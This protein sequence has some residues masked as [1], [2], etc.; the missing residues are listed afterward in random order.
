LKSKSKILFGQLAGIR[1]KMEPHGFVGAFDYVII[2]GGL[3]GGYAASSIRKI[4][5]TGKI[6]LVANE[7]HIPY[8]RVP[9]SKGYLLNNIPKDRLFFK[10]DE[11]YKKDGV[12]FILGHEVKELHVNSKMLKLDD[13]RELAFRKLLLATGGSPK[14]ILIPGSDLQGVY[15]LRTLE[16]CDLLKDVMGHSRRAVVIGGGFIGCELASAFA[17]KG[18]DTTIIEIGPCLL[19][20]AIDEET[21]LWI[22]N[23]YSDRGVSVLVNAT[24][25]KF[26]EENGRVSGIQLNDGRVISA[27][28]VVVGVGIALHTKLAERAG[29]KV[30]QG[31]VVNEFL[32]TSVEGIYAAGDVARFYSPIFKRYLRLEHYDIAVKHGIRA[33]ANMAGEKKPFNDLPYFFSYQFDLKI[34]AYGDLSQKTSMVKRGELNETEGFFQFYLNKGMLDAVLSINKKWEEVKKAKDLVIARKFFPDPTIFSNESLPL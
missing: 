2:G 10:K 30:D 26:L 9:L 24:A 15:Y 21:G 12:E 34:S 16:D 32:E 8:D 6:L 5:R 23:Y 31:I 27:D 25:S 29:L 7:N 3:A 20:M 28:F 11:F 4:D 18:L 14:R 17:T 1:S 22:G 19:N 33:G 13:G